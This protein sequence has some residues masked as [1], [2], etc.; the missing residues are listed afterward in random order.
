M[1][2]NILRACEKKIAEY[3]DRKFCV[4]TANGTTALMAAYML[5]PT[6]RPKVLMPAIACYNPLMAVHF[7][8]KIPVLADVTEQNAT[9][10]P[11]AV[12]R[13]LS[14]DGSIGAIVAVHLYGHPAQMQALKTIASHYDVM[15][16]EDQA[17][18]MGGRFDDGTPLGG[19]GD[20]SIISFGH[21]KILD[22]GGGG[23]FLTDDLG[24][25]ENVRE[26]VENL[27][28]PSSKKEA[29]ERA[30][31]R[32]Y[33]AIWESGQGDSRFYRLFDVFPTLFR[34]LFLFKPTEEIA[35]RI[36]RGM[37]K[38]D[39]EIEHRGRISSLY[40]D[41]LRNVAGIRFFQPSRLAVPWRFSFCVDKRLRQPLLTRIRSDGF[42]ISNWY[43]NLEWWL[44]STNTNSANH[45][46]VARRIEK[47]IV[48]LWVSKD[49]SESR[50][51]SMAQKI[52]YLLRDL[53]RNH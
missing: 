42:D 34:E 16:V 24:F 6:T 9:I 12:A 18:A 50:A 47:E 32:L 51:R 2:E 17:Q 41:E 25:H 8:G 7:A 39:S 30:Y 26:I 5:T 1:R 40:F 43:P 23:A 10:D 3:F 13:A 20:V 36:V 4:L 28:E 35:A 21:T 27:P 46:P 33:Y 22:L 48:N 31:R 53:S 15:L 37:D 52:K 19:I 44:S 11:D 14:R 29:L 38:L 45:C 49:Y